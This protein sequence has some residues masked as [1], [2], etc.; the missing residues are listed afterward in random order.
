MKNDVDNA[1]NTDIPPPVGDTMPPFPVDIDA[2]TPALVEADGA[3]IDAGA[4]AERKVGT[5]AGAEHTA[6]RNSRV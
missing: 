3:N 2:G 4:F 5:A 1:P 6:V